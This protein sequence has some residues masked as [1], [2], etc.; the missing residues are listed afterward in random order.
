MYRIPSHKGIES[1]TIMS[2]ELLILVAVARIIQ[3]ETIL[4]LGTSM[5]YT[6]YHLALNT[7]AQITTIDK[8][9]KDHVF[10]GTPEEAK[11]DFSQCDLNDWLPVPC[12]MVFCDVNYTPDTLAEATTIAFASFPRAVAWHDYGHPL[13]PHVKPFLDNLSEHRNLIHIEDSW[14]VLWFRDGL[15]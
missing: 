10:K 15:G 5:G 2:L 8:E 12:D 11:I 6:A 7:P 9:R 3:A 13:I 1:E 4:E 14:L